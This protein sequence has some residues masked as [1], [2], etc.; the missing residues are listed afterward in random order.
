MKI[1]KIFILF[2]LVVILSCYAKKW[3]W[4]DR[5]GKPP[6]DDV[7]WECNRKCWNHRAVSAD[8]FRYSECYLSCMELKGYFPSEIKDDK[9]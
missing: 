5:Y 2:I 3:E 9:K 7:K 4:F 6:S 8:E 1:L